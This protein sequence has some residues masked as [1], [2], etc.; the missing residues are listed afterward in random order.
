LSAPFGHAGTFQTLEEVL[1]Y[2]AN[3]RSQHAQFDFSLHHLDQFIDGSKTYPNA[4]AYTREAVENDNLSPLLPHR[5]M[6][7]NELR[8]LK[9]FLTDL[10]DVCLRDDARTCLS[11]WVPVSSDDPDGNLL[12][13]SFLPVPVDSGDGDYQSAPTPYP[14]SFAL[15]S[16]ALEPLAG[17]PDAEDCDINPSLRD[18]TG[19]IFVEVSSSLGV[20]LEHS[21]VNDIWFSNSS[22]NLADVAQSGGVSATYLNDDCWPDIVFTGG[23]SGGLKAF[24]NIEGNTFS[25]ADVFPIFQE[26]RVTGVA[27]ADI[28]GDFR[29]EMFVGNLLSGAVKVMKMNALGKYVQSAVLPMTR[30]TYG[31][32]FGDYD[33]DGWPDI[34]MAHWDGDGLPGTAPAL[35]RNAEGSL[36]LPVD[37]SAGTAVKYG[38]NQ[39]FHF[40]PGFVDVDRDGWLDLLIA[41]DFGSSIVLRNTNKDGFRFFSDATNR[42]VINDE[43]G[44]G[45]AI[46]DIDNDGL[47]DWFVTSIYDPEGIS[48]ASMAGNWG[49]TGN[50]LYRNVSTPGNPVF[51]NISNTAG[52]ADGRWGWGA[53]MADFNHDGWLDIL[54]VNGFGRDSIEGRDDLERSILASF[55]EDIGIK[56]GRHPPQLFLNNRNGTFTDRAASWGMTEP[57]DGKGIV[58]FDYDRDGDVDVGIFEHTGSMKFYENKTG[59]GASHR[60]LALRLEGRAPLTEAIGAR[61]TVVADIDGSGAIE[62][63]EHQVRVV[64]ANSNFNSQN[65]TDIHF[66]LGSASVVQSVRIDWPDGSVQVLTGQP[67]NQMRI[68]RQP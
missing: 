45:S 18:N 3:P 6:S 28:D 1:V 51:E 60:F 52:I 13:R 24:A 37:G 41:A 44:M 42:S 30:N 17:F 62:V 21:F 36:L 22:Y 39:N 16:P 7:E 31:F 2:H 9:S 35:W 10:T 54:H 15:A 11:P 48:D 32:A 61:V 40:T 65:T 29:R 34:Y 23:S 68:I 38:I 66:G 63:G 55:Y 43:N 20:D 49:V 33:G 5:D 4:Y 64:A 25:P 57:I 27:F 19:N 56:F 26:E 59:S 12:V 47:L 46:G 53:C 58:C 8:Y 14:S 50:R 67:V